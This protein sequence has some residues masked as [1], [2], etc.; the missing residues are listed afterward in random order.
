MYMYACVCVSACVCNQPLL[1]SHKT[2]ALYSSGQV[3]EENLGSIQFSLEYD[4]DT[5][6]L[7]LELM[8]A[9]DLTSPDNDTLPNP[10]VLVRL[11]PDC[12]NQLQTR[13]HRQTRC[14][15]L[16]ERFIFDVA[17]SEL[18]SRSVEVRVYNERSDDIRRDDC[19][20]QVTVPLDQ[21]DLTDKCVLCK[22]LS[23]AEKQVCYYYYC[24][25]NNNY[26]YYYYY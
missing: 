15:Y 23:A 25:Y 4:M 22:G 7:T 24:N 11:L 26:Y 6:L 3:H 10:Y 14:P 17:W 18:A 9:S 5:S 19:I 20:G 2:A 16:D 12:N 21:L 1:S 13:T 8:Q